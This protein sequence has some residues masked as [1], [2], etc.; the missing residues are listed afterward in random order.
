MVLSLKIA[1]I[2]ADKNNPKSQHVKLIKGTPIICH[3]TN[4]KLD[5]LNSDRFTITSTTNNSISLTN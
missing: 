1:E 4:K 5:I 3:R 2:P